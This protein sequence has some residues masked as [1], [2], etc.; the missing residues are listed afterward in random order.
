MSADNA[1]LTVDGLVVRY[2][3]TLA[4]RG[5]SFDVRRGETVC[6][7][8]PNGA[9]K[10]T[11]LQCIAGGI[12]A[13]EGRIHFNAKPIETAKP[14][15]IA[16]SGLSF[17]PEGRHVFG[18]LSVEENLLVGTYMR[19]DRSTVRADL[20]K[21]YEHFPR[22]AER[23]TQAGGKL[24]GGEQQ[25]LVIARALMTRPQIILIDEPSLGLAPMIIDQVYQ[26]LRTL[27]REEGLTLLIN[28]QGFDRVLRFADQ[29]LVLREGAIKLEMNGGDLADEEAIRDA[30]FGF[31]DKE[32][33][34]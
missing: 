4:V 33:A 6:I 13:E 25:M 10:S 20:A 24:S 34:A 2:G 26:I 8:G 1:I 7:V 29:V 32:Q 31:Q 21:I 17:V 3:R 30:Y 23:K 27:Q 14:E 11:T 19:R 28:E 16:L 22:L 9:G 5:I 18:S 12:R 15:V